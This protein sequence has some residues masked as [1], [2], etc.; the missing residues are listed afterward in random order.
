MSNGSNHFRLTG[1]DFALIDALKPSFVDD[2]HWPIEPGSL[3]ALVDMGMSDDMIAA[4]FQ[5]DL[6]LV[7][8]LRAR[9]GLRE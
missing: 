5:V 4:Y 7:L 3:A 1:G 8:A 9:Y 2:V 6:S